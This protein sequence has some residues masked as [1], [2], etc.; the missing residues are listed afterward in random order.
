MV[1][2]IFKKKRQPVKIINHC[3]TDTYKRCVKDSSLNRNDMMNYVYNKDKVMLEEQS[4]GEIL[5]LRCVDNK[6]IGSLPNHIYNE[7]KGEDYQVSINRI[8]KIFNENIRRD[9][10]EFE[11]RIEIY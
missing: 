3:I 8:Y 7:I 1:F 11:L 4:N 5:V 6:D 9:V 2:S 10:T